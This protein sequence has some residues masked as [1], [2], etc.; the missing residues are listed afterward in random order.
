MASRSS[1]SLCESPCPFLQR[2]RVSRGA[3]IRVASRAKNLV[4]ESSETGS[5]HAPSVLRT[6]Y[7]LLFSTKVSWF[8]R[9]TMPDGSRLPHDTFGTVDRERKFKNPPKKEH[10]V[11]ILNEFV[12]PH[13]ESFN[14]LFDDSGLPTGDG[15]GRGLLSL[16]LQDIGQRVIF[17]RRPEPGK[18]GGWGNRLTCTSLH[19]CHGK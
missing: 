14:A 12:T 6:P 17:D 2:A 11:P 18:E 7:S 13:L 8:Q 4:A 3:S 1:S 15:D 10:S 9:H 19:L 16:G 5:L